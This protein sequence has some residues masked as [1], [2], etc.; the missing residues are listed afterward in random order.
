MEANFSWLCV[1]KAIIHLWEAMQLLN[2]YR[3]EKQ[4]SSKWWPFN[5]RWVVNIRNSLSIG[6]KR[7]G[8]EGTWC[9]PNVS[10]VGKFDLGCFPHRYKS[11]LKQQKMFEQM[12]NKQGKDKIHCGGVWTSTRRLL[13][14]PQPISPLDHRH[15]FAKWRQRRQIERW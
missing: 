6:R 15:T 10:I 4:L 11:V 14:G 2:V 13:T 5:K 1:T 3:N 12:D 8:M 7:E 9:Q